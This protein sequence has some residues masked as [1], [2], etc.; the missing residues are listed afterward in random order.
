MFTEVQP[1]DMIAFNQ[2]C[3]L[4]AIQ[5]ARQL[6]LALYLSVNCLSASLQDSAAG[7]RPTCEIAQQLGFASEQ[8]IFVSTESERVEDVKALSAVFVELSEFDFKTA[9]R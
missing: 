3:R 6:N 5:F 2:A 7:I 4:K 9:S 8:L 1:S